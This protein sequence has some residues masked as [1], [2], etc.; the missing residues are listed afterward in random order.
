MSASRDV[1]RRAFMRR[2]WLLRSALRQFSFDAEHDAAVSG[3][4]ASRRRQAASLRRAAPGAYRHF[5]STR[6]AMFR[7]RDREANIPLA[8]RDEYRAGRAESHRPHHSPQ[9]KER[10]RL[11]RETLIFYLA[12][13]AFTNGPTMNILTFTVE[14]IYKRPS[15]ARLRASIATY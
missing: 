6:F 14:V 1:G 2:R 11:P 4:R 8:C 15:A 9:V 3:R 7:P 5:A 10:P 13:A 12:T